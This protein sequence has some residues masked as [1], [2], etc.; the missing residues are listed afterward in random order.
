MDRQNVTMYYS[1]N[2]GHMHI[3]AV[4]AEED[5]GLAP[6]LHPGGAQYEW[7]SNDLANVDRSQFPWVVAFLHRPLY[8]TNHD[9]CVTQTAS[10]LIY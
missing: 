9:K 10:V 4:S 8:C 7:L 3:V 1:F 5:W 6:D 2:Y